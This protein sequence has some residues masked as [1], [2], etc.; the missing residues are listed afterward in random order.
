MTTVESPPEEATEGTSPFALFVLAGA[1]AS[2]YGTLFTLVSDYR[3]EYGISETTIGW[4]IGIGFIVAFFAQ[5]TLGPLG[6]RGRAKLM[7]IAGTTANIAGLLMLAFGETATILMLGRVVSGIGTGAALPALKR[8][9]VVS[10]SENLG[11]NLGI[12]FS[13]E[14]FGF[15]VGPVI[16]AFLVGPLGIPGPFIVIAV[17]NAVIAAYVLVSVPVIETVEAEPSRFAFDLLRHRPF[18]GAI[19]LGSATF[20][21]IGTFDSLWDVVHSDL[22]TPEWM[23]N[24]GIAIFAIPLVILGPFAGRLAQQRGPFRIA[25]IGLILAGMFLGIYGALTVGALIFAFTMAH[26]ITDGM[27]FAASGVAVGMTAPEHRQSGAQGLLGGMQALAAGIMAPIAG[28]LY[29]SQGQRAAYWVGAATVLT[30]TLAGMIVAGPAAW[31]VHREDAEDY[32]PRRRR[33]LGATGTSANMQ[34]S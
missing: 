1:L 3:D 25:A 20:L 18:A 31:S 17:A 19:I 14:V 4:I 11:R 16:S 22:D 9:V 12:L 6:D 28:W 33:A 5:T 15:A 27:T 23:A 21:M 34:E 2:G 7:I 29:E 10:S 24:L 26:A 30:M 32:V 8:I 13:A